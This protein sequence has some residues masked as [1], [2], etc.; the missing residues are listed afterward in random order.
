MEWPFRESNL[1][2]KVNVSTCLNWVSSSQFFACKSEF[3]VN[4]GRRIMCPTIS[5]HL[6]L[7]LQIET[8]FSKWV[9][10]EIVHNWRSIKHDIVDQWQCFCWGLCVWH[11]LDVMSIASRPI[12]KKVK[13]LNMWFIS[14]IPNFIFMLQQSQNETML[15]VQVVI[16]Q[17]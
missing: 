3:F 8:N 10:F 16:E 17:S 4:N 2:Y 7:I 5:F 12:S 11:L 13:Q 1:L 15:S 6:Y 9:V 14:T